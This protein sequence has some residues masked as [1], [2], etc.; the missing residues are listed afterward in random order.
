MLQPIFFFSALIG[1]TVLICQFVM[2]LI[3]LGGDADMGLAD[4]IPDDIPDLDSLDVPDVDAA[5]HHVSSSW[6]F[7]IISFRTL[8]AAFT[9]F[10]LA[11]MA[12]YSANLAMPL[13]IVIA[14]LAGGTAMVVVHYLMQSFYRLSQT[15]TLR[16]SNA[17]GK[18]ATVYVPIPG[19]KAGQGKVQVKVQDRLEEFTAVTSAEEKLATGAKVVVVGVVGRTLEVEP[20]QE[21]VEADA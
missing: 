8:V 16:I 21:P 2:T 15:G 18:T 14:V 11:G 12:A 9:F 19:A 17:V 10:G 6:L 3:G 4:D 7:G 5:D 13:Q 1:G 20:L